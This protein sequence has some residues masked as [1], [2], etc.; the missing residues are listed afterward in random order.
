MGHVCAEF[1]STR[2]NQNHL[3]GLL[4]FSEAAPYS[5][6][7]LTPGRTP[8]QAKGA[9]RGDTK[10]R[11]RGWAA[12]PRTGLTVAHQVGQAQIE[13]ENPRGPQPGVFSLMAHTLALDA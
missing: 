13:R 8:G 7:T 9:R 3:T 5:E 6:R 12:E 10:H 1:Q 11:Q 2:I 4:D